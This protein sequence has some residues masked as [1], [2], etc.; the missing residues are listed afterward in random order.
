MAQGNL[1]TP[2]RSG[3][4]TFMVNF[5]EVVAISRDAQLRQAERERNDQAFVLDVMEAVREQVEAEG[6]VMT[7]T[8][9]WSRIN[10]NALNTYLVTFPEGCNIH[11]VHL[12]VAGQSRPKKNVFM[13]GPINRSV[14]PTEVKDRAEAVNLVMQFLLDIV[15]ETRE[16]HER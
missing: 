2:A 13:V 11:E 16:L 8:G 3:T 7:E 9:E 12:G 6:G 1:P 4:V 14:E 10:E 5:S 15:K